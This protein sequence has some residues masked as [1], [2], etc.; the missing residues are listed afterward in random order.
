[1]NLTQVVFWSVFYRFRLFH[2]QAQL[3]STLTG[4][5]A[6][7]H[8]PS[9]GLN[10]ECGLHL[11]QAFSE[12]VDLLLLVSHRLHLIRQALLLRFE[13]L[14]PVLQDVDLFGLVMEELFIKQEL[15]S[16][17]ILRREPLM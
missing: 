15:G 2:L 4:F 3:T 8:N 6:R 16:E 14:N 5:L 11:D 1:M 10:A 12:A 13:F 9:I 7:R 17:L